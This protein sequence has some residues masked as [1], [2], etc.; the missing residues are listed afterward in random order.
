MTEKYEDVLPLLPE[1]VIEYG[2]E[3]LDGDRGDVVD[4]IRYA[5]YDYH[6]LASLPTHT[7]YSYEITE[8]ASALPEQ[9]REQMKKDSLLVEENGVRLFVQ[10]MVGMQLSID[11]GEEEPVEGSLFI[12]QIDGRWYLLSVAGDDELFVY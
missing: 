12:V 4:F 1:E 9:T 11:V 3:Y 2:M 5:A 8:I 6:W 7:D 10:D